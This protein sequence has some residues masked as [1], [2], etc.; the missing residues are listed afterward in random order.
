MSK[1]KEK[2]VVSKVVEGITEVCAA[3]VEANPGLALGLANLSKIKDY[4]EENWPAAPYS[5]FNVGTIG[6]R[7]DW[8]AGVKL[9]VACGKAQQRHFSAKHLI[10]MVEGMGNPDTASVLMQNFTDQDDKRSAQGQIIGHISIEH[11]AIIFYQGLS[12]KIIKSYSDIA[13]KDVYYIPK[14]DLAAFYVVSKFQSA[15]IKRLDELAAANEGWKAFNVPLDL[16]RPYD[17]RV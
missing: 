5:D 14:D 10:A 12:G 8:V 7:S 2:Q 13:L 6:F 1:S 3:S 9:A 4:T 15:N 16:K 17:A 11:S